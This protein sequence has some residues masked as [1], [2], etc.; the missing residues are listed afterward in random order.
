[1]A[2]LAIAIA[3]LVLYVTRRAALLMMYV[4]VP[5]VVIGAV[6]LIKGPGVS[7]QFLIFGAV[8]I[9]M[10]LFRRE[11]LLPEARTRLVLREPGRTEAEALGADMEDVAPELERLDDDAVHAGG[12][13][14]VAQYGEEG[15]DR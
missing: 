11:G 14:P 15:S 8:L 10:M 13:V 5:V 7:F 9:I 4:G 2:G 6:L 1:V 12:S 3:G